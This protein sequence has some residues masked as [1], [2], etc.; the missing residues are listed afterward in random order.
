M[1]FL[2]LGIAIT[3]ACF[4]LLGKVLCSVHRLYT[5]V[6]DT[7]MYGKANLRIFG[8]IPSNLED[9]LLSSNKCTFQ[10]HELLVEEY[11]KAFIQGN[12]RYRNVQ[13]F[14][15]FHNHYYWVL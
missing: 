3:V 5:C 7:T 14:K 4:S 13:V 9:F 1:S 12:D 2:G 10:L 15:G 8:L 11:T 6:R